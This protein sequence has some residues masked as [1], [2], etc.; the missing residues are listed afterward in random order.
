M[1]EFVFTKG[2]LYL[3]GIN[4]IINEFCEFFF[5]EQD[6]NKMINR[7][8]RD[9]D[10]FHITIIHSK[11]MNSINTADLDNVI[12][13]FDFSDLDILCVGIGSVTNVESSSTYVKIVSQRLQDIRNRYKLSNDNFHV[14]LDFKN[15]DVHCKQK[16]LT[17]IHN[18]NETKLLEIL[19]TVNVNFKE[20]LHLIEWLVSLNNTAINDKICTKFC[21]DLSSVQSDTFRKHLA[22]I[23]DERNYLIGTF[24]AIKSAS[25]NKSIKLIWNEFTLA[26]DNRKFIASEKFVNKTLNILNYPLTN[27]IKW[28]REN[29][30]DKFFRYYTFENNEF[31]YVELPRNF[32]FVTENMAGSSLPSKPI[33]FDI[34]E[35]LG[36]DCVITLMETPLEKSHTGSSQVLI[37]HFDVDDRTPPTFDQLMEI[38]EIIH[39]SNKTLVHCMGGVGRTATVLLSYVMIVDKISLIEAK[40]IISER[41]TILSDSQEE[42]LRKWYQ[43]CQSGEITI[44]KK[45]RSLVKLPSLIVLMG[46]PASGKSTFSTTMCDQLCNVVRVNQDEIRS[47]GKCEELLSQLTKQGKTVILDRCNLSKSDRKYWVDLNLGK[48]KIWCIYFNATVEECKWRIKNRLNHPT[49]KPH[50]G[51]KIIDCQK[52]KLDN[53]Q[54]TEGFDEIYTISSFKESNQWLLKFGCDVS[55]IQEENHDGII[56]FPRTRHLYNLGSATRDDLLLDKEQIKEFL[57]T[58]IYAEE[59]IDGANMGISIK[60]FKLV[61]QNRSHYVTSSYHEQFKLLD[62]WINDHSEDLW[63]ILEDSSKILFG[64]WVYAKHSIH[65]T[66]LPDYF[67]AFDLYD[68]NEGRFYSRERLEKEL[69]DTSINLIPV[70]KHD[71]FK[72][73]EDIVKMVRSESSFY[74][75]P[76]EGLYV[77]KCTDKW[78]D[79]RAKIVRNDFICGDEHWSKGLLTRNTLSF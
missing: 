40:N 31:H 1:T 18:F 46:L 51:E 9:G 13:Q 12:A 34:F 73:V 33:Y 47:K 77:R 28:V 42:F 63:K 36:F 65:Y 30:R 35:K 10:N 69:K 64:E 53:P 50:S 78:L 26:V 66:K 55:H 25:K 6:M 19:D 76:I 52:S 3:V 22:A 79:N 11:E 60:D 21:D 7:K 75:G 24:L 59:K 43:K 45:T 4:N 20:H 48:N 38:M 58:P 29:G 41:K 27:N 44:T 17:T 32:S 57:N 71:V 5:S 39:N 49:V 2:S 16:S 56:K 68:V 23:L 54:K 62:Q 74:D 67:V 61:V 72:T 15:G 8:K 37:K 14:T 70:I